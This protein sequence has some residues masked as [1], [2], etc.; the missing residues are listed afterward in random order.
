MLRSLPI[1]DPISMPQF[2]ARRHGPESLMQDIVA[3]QIPGLFCTSPNSWTAAS[4]P[5]GAGV[6]DLV[7]VS[8]CPQVF[9]LAN[10]ELT[11]AQILAYLR[12]VGKARLET[13][14]ER[15]GT[16]PKK[17]RNRLSCLVDAEAIEISSNSFS[18]SPLW[19]QILPEIITIEVK[20]S[21]W[22]KA[23]EQA[24]RNR[25]FA[26][27]SFV[28][29]PGAVA[30]RVRTEPRLRDLGIG[31]ISVSEDTTA[32]VIKRPRRRQPIVWTYYYRLASILARSRPD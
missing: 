24:A 23:I 4:V 25:I 32:T 8:Y 13:I 20:V 19:R 1:S 9:A 29:L 30:H 18:L 6:P 28:A 31:L 27:L 22:Q 16:S 14:A 17:L 2:R 11:D 10:A 3:G 15:M 26:H 12:A 7:V 21:K 5:L